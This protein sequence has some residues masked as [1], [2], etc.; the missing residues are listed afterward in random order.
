M[1]FAPGNYMQG[2]S[3]RTVADDGM[4]DGEDEDTE[5]ID[6]HHGLIPIKTWIQPTREQMKQH[7]G[8]GSTA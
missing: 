7:V 5:A 4:E 1:Y 8:G 2:F 3:Q 6:V